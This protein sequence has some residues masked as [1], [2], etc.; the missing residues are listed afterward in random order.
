MARG[1]IESGGW[2][3]T[4]WHMLFLV[5][6]F[7][8]LVIGVDTYMVVVAA[9]SWT[10]VVVEDSYTSGQ[11]FNQK[12]ALVREQEALGWHER[13]TYVAG[14]LRLEVLGEADQPVP[15]QEPTVALSRPLGDSEDRTVALARA[16]D[17]SFVAPVTLGAGRWNAVITAASAQGAYERHEQLDLP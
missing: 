13:L 15:L 7:F 16:A 4:G 11:G 1:K 12:V 8:A 3:F 10:G 2:R 5:L 9:R 6:A 14:K 17:G